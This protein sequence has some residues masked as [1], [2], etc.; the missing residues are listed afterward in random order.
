MSKMTLPEMFKIVESHT[1]QAANAIGYGDSVSLRNVVRAWV[2][3]DHYSGGG[4]DD[5]VLQ[6]YEATDVAAGTKSAI[7]STLPIWQ[8]T[9]TATSDALTRGTDAAT[10]TIDTGAGKNQIAMFQFDPALFTAGYDCLILRAT[11]EGHASNIFQAMF[12]LEM[13]YMSKL[14]PSAIID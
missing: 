8:N 2:V 14:P 11:D 4:D 7:A 12:F 3:A 5:V 1:P 13:A 10:I 9:D 6:L